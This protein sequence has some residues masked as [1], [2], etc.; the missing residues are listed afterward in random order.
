MRTS[1]KQNEQHYPENSRH[2]V[3]RRHNNQM[4]DL[5]FFID[6]AANDAL[7][8]LIIGPSGLALD[9]KNNLYIAS[10]AV[11]S[12]FRVDLISRNFSRVAGSPG[13]HQIVLSKC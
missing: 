10:Y 4:Y 1:N 5:S 12:V 13:A 7:K 3:H 9:N 2:A 6:H 8:S 11:D